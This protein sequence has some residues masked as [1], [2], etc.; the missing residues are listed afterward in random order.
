MSMH[1]RTSGPHDEPLTDA[2]LAALA[3]DLES[4]LVER[5]AAFKGDVPNA[6]REAVCGFANDM[7]GHGRPGRVLIGV[8]DDG[9]PSGL[10]VNDEL[11]RQLADIKTDGNLVPPP[12]MSVERR[13]LAGAAVAVVTVRPSD[14]PPV[15]FRGRIWVRVG[16]RRALAT[17]Q[18]ERILNERRRH[19]DR[20]FD[21]SPV[22]GATL[23]DLDLRR[24]EEEYLPAAFAP[25]VL[26]ANGRTL[27]Q[28]LAS[29]KMIRSDDDRT[30]TV[31]GM[32]VLGRSPRAFLP[33]AYVQ[34]LRVQ[35][36]TLADPI[37]D[38][39]LIEG[40]LVDVV[41]RL[42]E[43]LE[44]HNRVAVDYA[45]RPVEKRTPQYPPSAFKQVT[46]NA[47]LHRTYEH[48][49]APSRVT[50][51]DDRID[52]VSPGGPYGEVT[53]ANF[54]TPGITDY[55]NP[56]LAEAM[57]VLGLV[58]RFGSGFSIAQQVLRQNGNPDLAWKVDAGFVSVTMRPVAA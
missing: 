7:P 58:Q 54:G 55:R 11:L 33:G 56:N 15:R 39:L 45:D 49:N 26:E 53:A 36:M 12:S 35:G 14:S 13:E 2:G 40:S 37:V 17:S 25:E 9:R 30:P 4:E 6:V 24:Y 23:A 32:L 48:T 8:T 46:R 50:W 57:R 34:F 16:P 10:V 29:T 51:F 3:V 21:V 19:K 20:P 1:E 18:E 44:A 38:E 22:S 47:L 5:K 31:V 41:R 52:V 27:E 42:D 43:K 28:R